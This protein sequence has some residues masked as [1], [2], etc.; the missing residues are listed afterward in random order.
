MAEGEFTGAL[1]VLLQPRFPAMKSR[2]GTTDTIIKV[3]S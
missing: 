1:S 3:S 2:A